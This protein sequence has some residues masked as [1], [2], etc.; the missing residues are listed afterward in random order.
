[1]EKAGGFGSGLLNGSS[2]LVTD[3]RAVR[4]T[5][6]EGIPRREQEVLRQPSNARRPMM[7]LWVGMS[8][9]RRLPCGQ[10]PHLRRRVH[11]LSLYQPNDRLF[12]D[13]P[14]LPRLK[15]KC[16][17]P[18]APSPTSNRGM[19]ANLEHPKRLPYAS[20]LSTEDPAH[21]TETLPPDT[22]LEPRIASSPSRQAARG[23]SSFQNFSTSRTL[24]MGGTGTT[25]VEEGN[26]VDLSKALYDSQSACLPRR[27][28]EATTSHCFGVWETIHLKRAHG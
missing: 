20:K 6:R 23:N 13:L 27:N 25:L 12:S 15:C 2:G 8:H 3:S 26:V 28:Y 19:R 10:N 22:I 21:L 5:M 7:P 24:A 18:I 17:A 14:L 4:V 9:R 16:R 11:K 1:M